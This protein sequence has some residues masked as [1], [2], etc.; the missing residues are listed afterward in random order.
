M[1]ILSRPISTPLPDPVRL[2]QKREFRPRTDS[3]DRQIGKDEFDKGVPKGRGDTPPDE[4]AA[5]A[6]PPDGRPDVVVSCRTQVDKSGL[7][8]FS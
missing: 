3:R 8:L 6:K 4:Q 1:G 5:A 7:H 2:A